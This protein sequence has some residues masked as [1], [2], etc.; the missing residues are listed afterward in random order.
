MKIAI[1]G[2]GGSGKSSLTTLL[3]MAMRNRG[4]KPL[5]V[6]CDESNSG[7]Y[8]MLGLQ[9]ALS[10]YHGDSRREKGNKER[11]APKYALG[12]EKLTNVQERDYILI[13]QIPEANL[14]VSEG[15]RLVS[16][17]KRVS[18]MEGC[19]CPIGMLGREFLA[20]LKLSNEDNVL[21]VIAAIQVIWIDNR[22]DT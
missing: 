9:Q 14:A 1:C 3:A 21:M 12:S 15:I 5:V 16:I 22:I 6:D 7:L 8:R 13:E 20:K 19:A 11:L 17:G 2:K 4:L 10:S 18:S